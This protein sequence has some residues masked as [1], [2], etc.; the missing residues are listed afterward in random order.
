MTPL[1]DTHQ[2]LVYP[3]VAG[4]GWT[5]GIPALADQSFTLE[6]YRELTAGGGIAGA[7]FMETGVDDADYMAEARHVAALARG[8]GSGIVGLIASLHAVNRI[9]DLAAGT[10]S[11]ALGSGTRQFPACAMMTA[12]ARG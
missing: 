2:H 1:L 4:Y 8:T 11:A 6:R 3:E 9:A 10:V 5:R 12:N 7:L